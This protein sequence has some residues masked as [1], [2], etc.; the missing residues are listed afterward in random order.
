MLMMAK[1]GALMVGGDSGPALGPLITMTAGT[2]AFGNKGFATSSPNF[3]N[4]WFSSSAFGSISGQ[5]LVGA[6]LVGL[7][8]GDGT[9]VAFSGDQLALLGTKQVYIDGVAHDLQSHT[10]D[11]TYTY[12]FMVDIVTFT[13]GVAYT[14]QIG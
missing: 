4:Y 12:A 1:M 10:F 6:T 2:A 8:D 14:V 5:P 13:N 9:V 3:A 11:G 7:A